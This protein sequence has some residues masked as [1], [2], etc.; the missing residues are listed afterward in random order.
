MSVIYDCRL[1]MDGKLLL[2]DLM[3]LHLMN[4]VLPLLPH[5]FSS[6]SLI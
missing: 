5:I 4:L 2:P 6:S 1:L 3:Q